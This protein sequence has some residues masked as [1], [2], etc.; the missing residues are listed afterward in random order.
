MRLFFKKKTE[1]KKEFN[2]YFLWVLKNFAFLVL[3]VCV[4]LSRLRAQCGA[5][6]R[7]QPCDYELKTRAEIKSWTPNRLSH[8]GTPG[9]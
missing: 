1:D 8:Q 2:K 4:C 6:H 3:C 7:A 9:C 5:Q